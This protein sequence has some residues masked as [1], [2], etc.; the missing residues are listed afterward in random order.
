MKATAWRTDSYLQIANIHVWKHSFRVFHHFTCA[1][2]NVL[3][4]AALH[5]SIET[6]KVVKANV[7]YRCDVVRHRWPTYD[8][9]VNRGCLG[10]LWQQRIYFLPPSKSGRDSTTITHFVDSY[11]HG[12]PDVSSNSHCIDSGVTGTNYQFLIQYITT[13]RAI[14]VTA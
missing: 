10:T 13:M 6:W 7:G 1:E 4:R 2:I 8:N 9:P 11:T 12:N 5:L 3:R 14:W